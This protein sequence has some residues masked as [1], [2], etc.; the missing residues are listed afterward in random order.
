MDEQD[1]LTVA[2]SLDAALPL[3]TGVDEASLR[4]LAQHALAAERASE[5]WEISIL[6]TSDVEIQRMHL[7]FMGL[8]S[9]TDIM[10]FPYEDEP[11]AF[12]GPDVRGGDIVI[13]VDTAA[14]HAVDASWSLGDELRFLVLHGLLHLLGWDDA[15]D[16]AR[17]SMLARQSSLLEDWTRGRR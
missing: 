10:T 6:F 11:G 7:E 16:D 2:L 9:P 15:T 14:T 8:D 3:P 5:E 4:S 12:P 13:S 17:A 1:H